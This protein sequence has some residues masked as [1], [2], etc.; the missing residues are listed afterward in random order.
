MRTILIEKHG[1]FEQLSI[2]EVPIPE[3]GPGEVRVAVKAVSLNH[4]DVWVR[5]G[6]PGHHFP[7]PLVPSSDAAGVVDKLG[8]GVS[9]IETGMEVVIAPAVSCGAC[10][11]CWS[12]Q[13]H[14]CRSYHILGEGC[15]GVSAE[16]VCVPVTNI[17]AKPKRLSFPE[18][19]ASLLAF[20]TAWHMLVDRVRIKPGET[21]LVHAGA[22]G[23]GSAAIQIAN[24]HG[25]RVFATAGTD[26]KVAL[27]KRLGAEEAVNYRE[28][29]FHRE[30][31]NWAGRAGVDAVFEHVGAA[32][33]ENSLRCL[34]W[35]GRLVT[36]G[37]TS[38]HEV[39]MDL[40]KLFF[41]GWSILGSSMGSR[42]ELATL[43]EHVERGTLSPVID[44]ILPFS[45]VSE[46]HELIEQRELVGKVVL[47]WEDTHE[48]EDV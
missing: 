23:V 11:A 44:R 38:G 7:L 43:L 18:A 19:S 8:E 6:V 35:G 45:R 1:G 22:S 25:A 34:S 17:L 12:G 31:R 16:F 42:G 28:V 24:L 30:V 46:A 13:D 21:V 32:T 14:R 4:L 33:W 39:T 40:R 20:L 9:G 15:D 3:P 37:A 48:S 2:K 5:R 29:E 26:E 27:C 36:C 47:T 41:K 10:K